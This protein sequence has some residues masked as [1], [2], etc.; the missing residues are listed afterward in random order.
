MKFVSITKPGIIFGNIVTVCGG[1]F[2]ASQ[3]PIN[4]PLFA[5]TLIGMILVIASGCVFNNC[6]DRDIDQLMRRT[7][8]RVLAQGLIHIGIALLYASVLGVLGFLLLYFRTNSLT[9]FLALVGLFFYVVVYTLLL[10][11]RSTYGTI[12]GG[13]AGAMPPVVGY[14]AVS[15]S[16]DFGA[17]LLFLILFF[18]QIPHVYAISICQLNDYAIAR[19]PILPLKRSIRYTKITMLVYII[20]FT[21]FAVLPGVF[22]YAGLAY[23]IVAFCI[24]LGWF[25]LGLHG[26]TRQSDR[27]WSRKM[28]VFSIIGIMTLCLMM[29]VK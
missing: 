23:L 10:K 15:N 29:V 24:G 12:I 7:K 8:N 27:Y 18:W 3:G 1:F 19:I 28:F 2:L 5:M 4:F 9:A 6:I 16:F 20:A 14:C 21:F 25:I 26:F 17:M 22:G 13:V 11:R